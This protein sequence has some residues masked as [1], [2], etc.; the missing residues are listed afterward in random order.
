[1]AKKSQAIEPRPSID[2][3]AAEINAELNKGVPKEERR[4]LVLP[5]KLVLNPFILRRPT[6]IPEL[7]LALGGGLPAG[8]VFQIA[9][10]EG[11]GK[12][13][14]CHLISAQVQAIYGE[15]T[16]IGWITTEFPL[17]KPFAHKF[18]VKVA[19]HDDELKL[20]DMARRRVKLPGLSELELAQLQSQVGSYMVV[21][22][23]P[24]SRRLEAC[25]QMLRSN[26]FQLLIVDS[27][28]AVLTEQRDETPLGEFAQQSSEA[29]LLTEWQKKVWGAYS[30]SK[31]GEPNWTT[32]IVINQVRAN[33]NTSNPFSRKWTVGGAHAIKHGKIGDLWLSKGEKID[34]E[35]N[36]RKQR[37]GK[38]VKWEIAK[39]K[40]GFHEGPKG[41]I[42]YFYRT[43][44]SAENN[45]IK[46]ALRNEVIVRTGKAEYCFVDL[47][48]EVVET[49]RGK[50]KLF[51]RAYDRDFFEMVYDACLAKEEVTCIYKL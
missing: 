49:F 29:F 2:L 24:T 23:G 45:L 33:R 21:D 5:A 50:S 26:R 15:D 7:D 3:I 48:G 16:A 34:G 30:P 43:G 22:R 13:A 17:D 14:L 47:N 4:D 1:M 40:G 44:F 27:I 31:T 46:T 39:G 42:D 9:A 51:D 28:G 11:I 37:V 32:L 18:G 20:L 19:M 36:G 6:G 38:Q 10:P 25:V 35:V 41:T 12:N 8:G